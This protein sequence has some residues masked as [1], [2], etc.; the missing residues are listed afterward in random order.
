MRF[1]P[2]RKSAF[3]AGAMRIFILVSLYLLVALVRVSTGSWPHYGR[4]DP[5]TL[6]QPLLAASALVVLAFFVL[7]Y[8]LALLAGVALALSFL[9][10]Y[11][12][13]R[14]WSLAYQGA[15]ALTF[16]VLHIDPGGFFS[17]VMD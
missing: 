13:M 11:R 14:S 6:P 15:V 16:T 5:G 3:I 12:S 2:A 17:W 8:P 1:H 7:L 10:P 9:R 4:P